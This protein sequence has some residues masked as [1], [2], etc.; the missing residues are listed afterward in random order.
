VPVFPRMRE[1]RFDLQST[2]LTADSL[3]AC[4]VALIATDHSAF[5]Y[6]L[7]QKHAR[8]IVDTRGVYQERRP[9]VVKS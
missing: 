5:D 8:L 7:V 4:D 1:H 9:N 3:A 6:E 2:P